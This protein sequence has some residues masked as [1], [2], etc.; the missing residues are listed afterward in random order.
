M[1]WALGYNSLGIPIAAGVLFP[2]IKVV[3]PPE[4]AGL[5][6]AMS[7]VSVVISSLL[8]RNYKPPRIQSRYGREV[9]QGTLGIESVK[10]ELESE[11]GRR[12]ASVGY[13]IDPGCM[14]AYGGVCTCD[15]EL[16]TCVY[17]TIHKGGGGFDNNDSEIHGEKLKNHDA[18]C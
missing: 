9:R 13:K 14:M 10:L 3:L 7:S 4:V 17:C 2:I 11:S 6:M 8:L 12:G 1:F 5:A 18:G 15:A 16:C